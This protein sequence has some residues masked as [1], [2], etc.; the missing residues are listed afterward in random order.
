MER[1]TL[2]DKTFRIF[3]PHNEIQKSIEELAKKM[4]QDFNASEVPLFLSV[5]NGS[6]MFTSDLLKHLNFQCELSFIKVSSYSGVES[7]GE[8]KH[9]LGLSADINGRTV[10]LVEDIVDT[11]ATIVELY[12]MLTE[13]GAARV[14]ICTLLLKPDAYKKDIPVE[15]VAMKIP[16]DFIVGYGLDYDELGR[17]YKDIYVLDTPSN[18][19]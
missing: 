16:N 2:H 5:L 7:T 11:G 3:I 19:K 14:V 17:Q 13:A 10:V 6:F 9:I 4:N 8:L 12:K 18:Q 15:Y 1:I